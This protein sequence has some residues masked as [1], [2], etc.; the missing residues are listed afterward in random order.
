MGSSAAVEAEAPPF[1]PGLRR[2]RILNA[3]Y[4]ASATASV[5]TVVKRRIV[6]R[7]EMKSMA[8]PLLGEFAFAL[9]LA[10]RHARAAQLLDRGE[11]LGHVDDLHVVE[12]EQDRVHD[13]AWV[14]L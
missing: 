3:A 5:A 9:Q 7:I 1:W 12:A 6:A 14:F 2:S 4:A 10:P 8:M 11:H 13:E